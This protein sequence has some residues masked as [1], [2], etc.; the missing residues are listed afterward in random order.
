MSIQGSINSMIATTGALTAL[1]ARNE[2]RMAKAKAEAEKAVKAKRRQ[3]KQIKQHVSEMQ[4]KGR[5]WE[6]ITQDT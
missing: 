6:R 1:S 2:D 4:G 3:K 5:L